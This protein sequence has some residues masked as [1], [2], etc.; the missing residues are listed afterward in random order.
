MVE[1]RGYPCC[2]GALHVDWG[3]FVGSPPEISR[4]EAG[5]QAKLR[6]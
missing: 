5:E 4:F 2:G 3:D 6:I 1:P